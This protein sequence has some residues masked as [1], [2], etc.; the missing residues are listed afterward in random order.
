MS[1]HQGQS[2]DPR[3][4]KSN[5]EENYNPESEIDS[6]LTDSAFEFLL[7]FSLLQICPPCFG[8]S[9]Q[10]ASGVSS[11]PHPSYISSFCSSQHRVI[12]FIQERGYPRL[13]VPT[14]H[15]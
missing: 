8:S 5:T 12:A 14:H 15:L 13:T 11:T 2:D 9:F 6:A 10:P 1:A 7:F 3:P 4:I